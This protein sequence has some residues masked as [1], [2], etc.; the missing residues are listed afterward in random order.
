VAG[1]EVEIQRLVTRLVGDAT[2]HVRAMHE[3]AESTRRA[4]GQ[5]EH[6]T[7]SIAAKAV[8]MGTLAAHAVEY[9]IERFKELAKESLHAAQAHEDAEIKLKAAIEAGGHAADNG[10]EQYHHFATEVAK[11]TTTGVV[12]TEQL[13]QM[14]ETFG[15]HGKAAELAAKRAI[16]MSAAM[17]IGAEHAIRM[18]SRLALGSTEMMGRFIP[19]LDKAGSEADKLALATKRLDATWEVAEAMAKTSSGQFAMLGKSVHALLA[20]VGYLI[21]LGLTPLVSKTRDLVDWFRNLYSAS[22]RMF[23]GVKPAAMEVKAVFTAIRDAV[24][25][26]T[27][28]LQALWT[29]TQQYVA[30]LAPAAKYVW[31]VVRDSA[32]TAMIAV[33]YFFR[34]WRQFAA[35]SFAF[36]QYKV[37]QWSNEFAYYFG[38][39]LPAVVRAFDAFFTVEIGNTFRG[40]GIAAIENF[41]DTLIEMQVMYY[42]F[43]ERLKGTTER[44]IAIG[45]NAIRILGKATAALLVAN[46]EAGIKPSKDIAALIAA[47]PARTI[48][49]MEKLLG[50]TWA[51]MLV[52]LALGFGGFWK[53]RMAELFK[54]A[55]KGAGDE[56][57]GSIAPAVAEVKK[58]LD[59]S[60]AVQ[61]GTTEAARLIEKQ[62]AGFGVLDQLPI[63]GG[64]H[65]GKGSK[66]GA[67]AGGVAAQAVGAVAG[68]GMFSVPAEASGGGF[69]GMIVTLLQQ[70]VALTAEK[71]NKTLEIKPLRLG[72]G[73]LA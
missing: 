51:G 23:Q 3:A 55:G 49:P 62:L 27:S 57:K 39:Y 47:I 1:S 45:S 58:M 73:G 37:V 44:Q 4:T 32:L 40:A 8:A 46:L 31:T 65:G 41:G 25:P 66:K 69:D 14:A 52:N 34:N 21:S 16:G 70:L 7:D 12:A 26:I 72:G 28:S 18:T 17:G 64:K 15:V 42:E 60:D 13:L 35:L 9:V 24:F 43:V 11:V 48:G 61:V 20:D 33:E 29:F 22:G 6:D 54:A 67:I 50:K 53:T 56:F 68:Q 71:R 63:S 2:E 19:G 5:I 10:F 36:V 30:Y 38:S 59:L